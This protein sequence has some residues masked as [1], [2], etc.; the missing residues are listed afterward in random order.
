MHLGQLLLTAYSERML[1]TWFKKWKLTK[2]STRAMKEAIVHGELKM[3]RLHIGDV[4]TISRQDAVEADRSLKDLDLSM[5]Q[6]NISP[7]GRLS[8]IK[9]NCFVMT[10]DDQK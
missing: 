7:Q 9:D 3:E 5:P 2:Y 10:F 1:K 8:V 4:T 6:V